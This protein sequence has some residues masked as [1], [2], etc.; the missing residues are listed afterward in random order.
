MKLGL[1]CRADNTGLGVQTHDLYKFLQPHRTYVIDLTKVNAEM[2]KTTALFKD[3]YPDAKFIDGFPNPS[4]VENMLTDIDVLFTVEIPY[5]YDLFALAKLRGVKTILHY[6]YEFLDYLEQPNLP[7][8]D[9]MLAPSIWHFDDVK[10]YTEQHYIKLRYL[11]PPVDRK[12][13]PFYQ[14]TAANHFVHVAGHKTF[15]DRNGTEVVMESLKY[16]RSDITVTIHTQSK[17][18]AA[19]IAKYEVPENVTLNVLDTEVKNYQDIYNNHNYDVLLL[20]RRYGGLSLQ[21]NEAMSAGLPVIMPNVSPNNSILPQAA[22]IDVED[23]IP[24][25]TRTALDCFEISPK[26]LAT[27]I[28]QLHANTKLVTNLSIASDHAADKISWDNMLPKYLKLLDEVC[29]G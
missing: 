14:R 11:P 13:I 19:D 29:Q 3:R 18:V 20:P 2:G 5:N 28:E 6:N 1:I 26:K 23:A 7:A 24:I 21:L 12:L 8:P 16:I 25:R 10:A 9:L 4:D 22:L 27:K 17:E 15:M